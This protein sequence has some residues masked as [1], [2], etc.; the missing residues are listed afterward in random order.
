M[1]ESSIYSNS[2]YETDLSSE[3]STILYNPARNLIEE[4][5]YSAHEIHR[6]L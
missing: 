3:T 4:G 2:F 6:N 5:E 1:F